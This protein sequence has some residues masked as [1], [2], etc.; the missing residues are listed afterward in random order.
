MIMAIM[1]RERSSSEIRAYKTM[2]INKDERKKE[3]KEIIRIIITQRDNIC[4]HASKLI[5]LSISCITLVS[6]PHLQMLIINNF[7]ILK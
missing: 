1:L 4:W 3:Q 7:L 5:K 2:T 6:L